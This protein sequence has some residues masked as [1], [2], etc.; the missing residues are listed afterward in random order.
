MAD[1]TT[2]ATPPGTGPFDS[3][4]YTP[5]PA[6]DQG[7]LLYLENNEQ[8]MLIDFLNL[9][10]R[11]DQAMAL[12]IEVLDPLDVLVDKAIF[13]HDQGRHRQP[14]VGARDHGR[15]RRDPRQPSHFASSS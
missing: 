1:E 2:N 12:A 11:E 7:R 14:A 4:T 9:L 10:I 5:G 8:A 3:V 15:L 6:V 13:G